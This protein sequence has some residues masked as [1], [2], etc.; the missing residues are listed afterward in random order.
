MSNDSVKASGGKGRGGSTDRHAAILTALE[1]RNE[2]AA[3]AAM[4]RVIAR[5]RGHVGRKARN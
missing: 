1:A 2:D 3:R 4:L 5:G